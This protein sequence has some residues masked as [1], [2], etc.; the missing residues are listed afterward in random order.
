M[1]IEAGQYISGAE[2]LNAAFFEHVSSEDVGC[3]ATATV[4]LPGNF[5]LPP[6]TGS[7]S[8]GQQSGS[9]MFLLFSSVPILLSSD[10]GGVRYPCPESIRLAEL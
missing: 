4:C 9:P 8:L 5:P 6:V 1:E 10:F 7:S 2:D 3:P